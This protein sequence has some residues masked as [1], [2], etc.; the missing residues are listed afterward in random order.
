MQMSQNKSPTTDAE[1]KRLR[2][3]QVKWVDAL[4]YADEV[5]AKV[6]TLQMAHPGSLFIRFLAWV[7][8]W[9]HGKT[10]EGEAKARA[11]A[12]RTYQ[13]ITPPEPGQ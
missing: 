1:T 6:E 2:E 12:R 4:G 3:E 7:I 5:K 13:T 8:G 9:S 10:V 11:A